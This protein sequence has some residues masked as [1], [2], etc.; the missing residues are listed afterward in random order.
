MPKETI[1]AIGA[2]PDDMEQFAGGTLIQLAK[3]GHDV[4]IAALTD[5]A[6]GSK[7]VSAEEIVAIRIEEATKAAK[8]IGARYINLG[9]RDGSIEY[10]LENAKKVAG[11]IRDINPQVI[12]THPIDDYM[13]DHFHTG[14]LVLWAVPESKHKNFETESKAPPITDQP[15]VYHTD[16]QGLTFGDGQYTRVNTI[17]DISDVIDQK[18][19]A[20]ATHESQMGFLAHRNKGN[21]VEKTKR[22]AVIRG[23]QV[24][25]EY[26]EGFCQQLSAEYPRKNILVELLPGKVITL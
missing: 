24:R 20:F 26:G 19:E 7:T 18:M 11:L 9:I 17:V 4:T 22:W 8:I 6:C 1:L 15:W 16:P 14:R 10:N 13:S 21:A 3:A 5:G 25:T 23:E 2:H 12:I